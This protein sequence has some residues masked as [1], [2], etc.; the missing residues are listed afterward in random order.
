[1]ATFLGVC[2]TSPEWGL[3]ESQ[4]KSYFPDIGFEVGKFIYCDNYCCEITAIEGDKLRLVGLGLV[5][6]NKCR[7]KE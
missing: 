7:E 6:R 2:R 5:E 4:A 3:V 1:M